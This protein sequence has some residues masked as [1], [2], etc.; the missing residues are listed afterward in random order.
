MSEKDLFG[1][2]LDGMMF[3]QVNR[4]IKRETLLVYKE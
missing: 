3:T 1:V 4:I 2:Y